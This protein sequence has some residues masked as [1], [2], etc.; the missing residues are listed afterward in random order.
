MLSKEEIEQVIR[1][2]CP[3]CEAGMAAEFRRE[4]N[5]FI[6]RPFGPTSTQLCLAYRLRLKY[7]DVLDG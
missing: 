5:E 2:S 7:K 3:R 4:T 1:D 6:H